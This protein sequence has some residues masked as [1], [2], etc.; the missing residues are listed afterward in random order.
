VSEP[1][2]GTPHDAQRLA[3][4]LRSSVDAE[5]RF[6]RTSR[7]LY[8]TDGSNYRQVPIGVVVPR[9]VDAIADTI[10][11]CRD[12]D[13][14]VL[15]RGG[16]T[17]L[18]GQCC[19]VA[20]V[21]D[22]SK[23]LHRVLEL[24][25]HTRTALVEPGCVLD[26]LRD[27]A[28]AHHLTFGPDPSTHDHNTLGGM[29]GNNSCGIHSVMAGRTADNVEAL[30]IATYDGFRG[31]VGATD[32]QQL[33]TIL[34]AGGP[35]AEIYR[36]LDALQS[37]HAD[38]IRARFPDIPRRVSGFNLN[39]LLPERGFQ[40]ARALVGSEGTC[41][42]VLRARLK[43]VPSPPGR[44]LLVLGFPDV[45]QAADQVPE[46]L[47][48]GPIG[49][50]GMDD[51][52]IE[53]REQKSMRPHARELLP[54]GGGWLLVEFGGETRADARRN[55]R[56]ALDALSRGG[57][58]GFTSRLVQDRADEQQIEH[59]RTGPDFD[60]PAQTL[61]FNYPGDG[62]SLER[63]ALRCVGVGSCR[64]RSGAVMCPSYQAT[65]EEMHSTRGRARLL[66]EMLTGMQD[67]PE[68]LKDG[69]R[70]DGVRAALD[71]CLACKACKSD[72]P[73]NID[74]AS[75][76]ADFMH[77]YYRGR[78]RPRA[79]YS[80]GLIYWWTR[81]AQVAP[82]LAN[83]IVRAPGLGELARKIAGIAPQRSLPRFATRSFTRQFGGSRSRS[84]DVLLWPDTFT[85]YFE[86]HILAAAVRVLEHAGYS[87]RLPHRPLCCARP[88][89]AEG[90]LDLA[91]RQ[92]RRILDTLAPVLATDTP[93]VGLEPACVAAFRDELPALF[94]DDPRAR[95][96]A[97]RAQLLD[98]FLC[99][100][101]YEPRR[102]GGR[103]LVQFH[104]NHHAI[105]D[106]ERE[107]ALLA[108]LLDEVTQPNHGCCGMAGSF[109]YDA[110]KY[111]VSVA[112]AE[113]ALAPAVRSAAAET[114]LIADGFACRDQ[115]RQLTGRRALHLAE[116]LDRAVT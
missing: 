103:G 47:A 45:Y 19:N 82:G 96:L 68:P 101:G 20:V 105:F 26:T 87:V 74:M 51:R 37:A 7:A 36:R 16:G 5:V 88:L 81:G 97:D 39:E 3:Q 77:R 9:T 4:A 44:Q 89:Y 48:H 30:E 58:D 64:R 63:V 53:F 55:A 40:V 46:I 61:A 98:E 54:E 99:G 67:R 27:A 34:R 69:W 93:I 102:L 86:P 21:I 17:S 90:M 6:D 32:R 11:V 13:A 65:G 115:I 72:C 85:N 50:E 15:L 106:P 38:E 1:P 56:A 66:F 22:A 10:A 42:A 76:K 104:C 31:W 33:A 108:A 28:E 109:G 70:S 62:R 80:L 113:A 91:R 18:A 23:Y 25:P 71:L 107:R 14:P 73:V 52:L 112:I 24:D 95:A 35:Q 75:Y 114:F 8:A 79:A 78:L 110:R 59:L 12:H 92:L 60:P 2:A 100:I 116:V 57:S 49:L 41:V 83:A 94:P 111:D 43:L 84:R 29:I